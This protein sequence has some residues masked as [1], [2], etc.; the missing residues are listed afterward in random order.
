MITRILKGYTILSLLLVFPLLS[1]CG[2]DNKTPNSPIYED[3]SVQEAYS[4][5]Q[6]NKEND[7]FIILDVRT[8][9]EYSSGH[10]ENAVNSDYYSSTF[11]DSLAALDKDK[12]YLVYCR[13]GNRS[14]KAINIMEELGF[15]TVYNMLGGIVKWIEEDLSIVT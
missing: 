9:Q 2:D 12:V 14:Q 8:P 10:L 15:N 11:Q 13:S 6:D 1:G 3:I 5:I 7:N 4:L